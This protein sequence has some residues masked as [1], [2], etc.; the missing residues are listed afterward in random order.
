MEWVIAVLFGLF[1]LVVV[2]LAFG[3]FFTVQQQSAAIVQ[4]FG[5]FV[6]VANPGLNIKLPLIESER[7]PD[8]CT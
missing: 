4:R 6:R 1:V 5:K 8:H 7:Q 2:F 3:P